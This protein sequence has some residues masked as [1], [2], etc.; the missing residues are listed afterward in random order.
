ML[1]YCEN[2]LDR[3][4]RLACEDE[5]KKVTERITERVTE[6]VTED[7]A[8]KLLRDNHKIDYVHKITD[9]PISRIKELKA[10]L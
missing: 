6:R 1:K 7:F 9:L 10:N 2:G 8:C 3:K 5:A 4:I